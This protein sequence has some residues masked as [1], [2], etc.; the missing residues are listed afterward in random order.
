M[1]FGSENIRKCGHK[2]NYN[3]DCVWC[4]RCEANNR[5]EKQVRI[6]CQPENMANIRELLPEYLI[7]Y[8][9]M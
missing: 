4:R 8:S 7:K 9:W 6:D 1:T 3:M 2:G 5:R